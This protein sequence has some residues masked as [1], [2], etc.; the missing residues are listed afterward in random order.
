MKLP[1]LVAARKEIVAFPGWQEPEPETGGMWFMTSL[2][3]GGVVQEGFYL[4]AMCLKFAPDWN[5]C[6]E[7]KLHIN[8]SKKLPLARYEWKSLRD[9]HTNPRRKGSPVSGQRVSRTHYHS[10]ELNWVEA[11]GR[12]RLGNLPMAV[13]IDQEPDRFESLRDEV[14]KLFRINNMSVVLPPPWEYKMFENG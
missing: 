12:M 4:H 3:A 11:E 6:F 10:F 1:E 5:V 13:N 9:G 8:K 2:S 14:G 7:L